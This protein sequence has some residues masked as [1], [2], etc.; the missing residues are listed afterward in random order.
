MGQRIFC[1]V[2]KGAKGPMLLE[3]DAVAEGVRAD[4][5][6]V[7]R[8]RF[9][10]RM[11]CRRIDG[12]GYILPLAG[13]TSAGYGFVCVVATHVEVVGKDLLRQLAADDLHA[14]V[15]L[16]GRRRSH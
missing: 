8:Q 5:A 4:D 10:R 16:R 12:L 9:Y 2:A 11:G 6:A 7:R 13:R 1:H 15:R 3:V 14:G